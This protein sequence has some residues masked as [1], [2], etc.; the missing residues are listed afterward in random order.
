MILAKPT[1]AAKTNGDCD[2][3]RDACQWKNDTTDD[4]FRWTTASISRR[5]A[6][7]P[8]HT[9]GGPSKY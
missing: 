3:Q 6:S 5:P 9:F 7:L 1:K 4:G 2:F 8:D